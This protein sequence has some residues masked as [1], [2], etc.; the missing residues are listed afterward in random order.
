MPKDKKPVKEIPEEENIITPE[1]F[2]EIEKK[3]K[4]KGVSVKPK[5]EKKP[6]ESKAGLLDRMGGRSG[7]TNVDELFLRL[8]KIE[9]KMEAGEGLRQA[10]EEKMTRL[11]EE[12]GELRSAILEKERTFNKMESGFDKVKDMFEEIKPSKLRADL[13]KKDDAIEKMAAKL[14]AFD[15]K[16]SEMK[17]SI[18]DIAGIMEKIKSL[19][20]MVSLS[21]NIS[22]KM[23][24]VEEDRNET[25]KIASK[26]ESMFS[27]LAE[28]MTEF[29]NYKDKIEFSSDSMHDIMKAM[30]M[31]EVKVENALKK[32]DMKKIDDRIEQMSTE[33]GDSIQTVRD[34]VDDL[35][36]SLKKGGV[37]D[38]LAKQGKSR[39]DEI[40][41]HL[42]DIG[43][44]EKTVGELKAQMAK[45]E[46]SNQAQTKSMLSQIGSLKKE[47]LPE[48]TRLRMEKTKKQQ[49][50][51][52]EE[53][54]IRSQGDIDGMMER[55]HSLIDSGSIE[56]ARKLY[57]SIVN[58]YEKS[59]DSPDYGNAEKVY[60]GIKKLYYRLQIYA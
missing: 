13:E 20:N 44:Y 60:S 27:E 5:P 6:Q 59:K 58:R 53:P 57:D 7:K 17:K 10:T 24:R 4:K 14:E 56:E 35:V 9:A 36:T 38:L 54:A 15:T 43:K 45:I 23:E 47:A 31:M 25:S 29:H 41:K 55:C 26:I 22:K 42:A 46:Q 28:K 51:M 37:K 19:K 32:D 1:E 2:E 49:P 12:I 16:V 34:I 11:S 3:E 8:E 39:I 48:T 52:S 33:L 30:D 40:N 21:E 18:S 50:D